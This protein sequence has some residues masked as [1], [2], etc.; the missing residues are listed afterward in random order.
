L[1]AKCYGLE[2]DMTR[3][4]AKLLFFVLLGYLTVCLYRKALVFR[5]IESSLFEILHTYD[6]F[7]SI[8]CSFL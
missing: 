3:L 6:I 8:C 1:I 5:K 4:T 7:N 2:L